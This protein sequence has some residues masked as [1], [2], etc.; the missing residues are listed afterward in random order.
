LTNFEKWHFFMKD[1]VSPDSFVSWGLYSLIAC[2]LQRKVW[3]NSAHFDQGSPLFPNMYIILTGEPGVG[4]GLVIKQ[5]KKMLEYWKRD[6]K[7]GSSGGLQ[8]GDEADDKK[9]KKAMH[10]ETLIPIGADS[11]TCEALIN[12]M[13]H[14]VRTHWYVPIGVPNSPKIPYFHSSLCVCLE[15]IST[16]FKKHTENLVNFML[17]TY[18]CGNFNYRT[19]GRGTDSIHN[20]CFNMLGGT[21]PTFIRRVF[22]QD[23]FDE[24]FS[25]RTIFVVEEQ[26]RDWR[27]RGQD[28]TPEQETARK[29]LLE[30]IKRLTTLFGEVKWGEGAVEYL[31]EWWRRTNV[32]P[33]QRP[34]QNPKLKA[35]YARKNI[36]AQ[37]L[38]MCLHFMEHTSMEVSLAELQQAIAI[39]DRIETKMHLALNSEGKNVLSEVTLKVFE[40]VKTKGPKSLNDLWVEF[41]EILPGNSKQSL[42]EVLEYLVTTRKL[43]IENQQYKVKQ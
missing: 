9:R 28:I 32:D 11:I 3:L 29:E 5:V 26:N 10:Q 37:K 33:T 41:Y 38:A 19:I 14:S 2:T 39:L 34:N 16:M 36:T 31:E 40:Y 21:T 20:C 4:K 30:H 35:Y 8:E 1:A 12:E 15:E 22:S 24:G 43:V 25:S 42:Q 18:D 23:M 17:Q 27:A 6:G 13:A 7:T